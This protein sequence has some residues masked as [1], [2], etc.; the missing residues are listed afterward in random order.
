MCPTNFFFLW[1]LPESDA[2][3]HAA[4]DQS[5]AHIKAV[6]IAEGVLGSNKY[7]NYAKYDTPPADIYGANLPR[8]ESIKAAVDP[9]N[10]MGLAGG[11]KF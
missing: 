4:M 8:L 5:I 2:I 3:F 7:T 10:V 1:L 9:Q 11:F 6:A